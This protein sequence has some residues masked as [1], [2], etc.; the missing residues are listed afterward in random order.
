M[1]RT[2]RRLIIVAVIVGLISLVLA[3]ANHHLITKKQGAG[4]Q[5]YGLLNDGSRFSFGRVL[6]ALLLAVCTILPVYLILVFVEAVWHTDFRFWIVPL[7]PLT[8]AR[9][10]AFITYFVPFLLALTIQG[11]ILTGFL[12]VNKGN[13]S[14]GKEMAVS[15]A[16]LTLGVIIWLALLYIPLMAG[17]SIIFAADPLGVTAAG[18]GGIYYIP[19][20]IFWPL[21]GCLY[22][23][24][25]RKTGSVFLGSFLVTIFLV[26]NLAGLGV[27]AFAL[28]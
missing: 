25:Y 9:F 7:L 8:A 14:L 4:L 2:L 1:K 18:M 28:S 23:F 12:R 27:F 17:G 3:F 13:A 24:F 11:I 5:N 21:A 16:V 20:L 15:A 26:W 22:T 10:Q 19:L 6:K